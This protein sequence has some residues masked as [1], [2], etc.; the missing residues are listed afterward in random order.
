MVSRPDLTHT[1]RRI[2]TLMECALYRRS[3]R[4]TCRKCPH[5]RLW[6]A[7]PI[8]WLFE[9]KGWCG[10]MRDVPGRLFCSHCWTERQERVRGPRVTISNDP[11]EKTPYPYPSEREWKRFVSRYRS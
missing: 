2:T 5:I 1:D 8:W 6:E 9:K 3:L 10:F 7:V 11:P 4:V